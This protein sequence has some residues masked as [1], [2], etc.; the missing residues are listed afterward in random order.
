M[1]KIINPW[2]RYGGLQLF[3]L[4]SDNEAGVKWSF[5]RTVTRW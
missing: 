5:M 2:N 1:K 3:R 4:L